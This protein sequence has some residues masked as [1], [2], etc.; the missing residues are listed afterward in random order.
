MQKKTGFIFFAVFIFCYTSAFSQFNE[1]EVKVAYIEKFTQFIEWPEATAENSDKFSIYVIGDKTIGWLME[2]YFKTKKIRNKTVEIMNKQR[3][4]KEFTANIIYI[5]QKD[6]D[7]LDLI[8]DKC[9]K[10]PFLII[11][12][13]EGF[14]RKGAHINF[15]I[16]EQQNVHFEINKYALEKAGFK[17]DFLLLEYANVITEK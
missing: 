3:L 13:S 2:D 8:V 9:N 16:T 10:S 11:S 1:K 4:D 17:T 15:Y 12:D 14:A 5:T 6:K 7:L